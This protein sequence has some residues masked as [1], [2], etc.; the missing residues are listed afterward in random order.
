METIQVL[1]KFMEKYLKYFLVVNVV[2]G[3]K[4]DRFLL[5]AYISGNYNE[6]RHQFQYKYG[7]LLKSIAENENSIFMRNFVMLRKI[8]QSV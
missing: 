2:F 8:L 5:S 4:N 7:A 6:V 3:E 1:I